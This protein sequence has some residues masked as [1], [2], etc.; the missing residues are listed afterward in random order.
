MNASLPRRLLQ[1]LLRLVLV[2]AGTVAAALLL[3]PGL[4]L[5]LGVYAWARLTGRPGVRMQAFRWPGTGAGPSAG[6]ARPDVIDVDVRE[7]HD[8]LPRVDRTH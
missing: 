3:V 6:G 2:L 1:T 4:V 7:V 8:P 5:G